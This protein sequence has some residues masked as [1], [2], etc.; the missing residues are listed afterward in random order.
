MTAFAEGRAPRRA[1]GP[2]RPS[3]RPFSAKTEQK[4]RPA[5]CACGAVRLLL[6]PVRSGSRSCLTVRPFGKAARPFGKATRLFGKAA[7]SVRRLVRRA[8]TSA[9][10]P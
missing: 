4:Y 3:E 8:V 9:S 7:R 2:P 1:F 6:R 10:D 5:G